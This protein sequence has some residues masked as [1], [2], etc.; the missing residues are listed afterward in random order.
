MLMHSSTFLLLAAASSAVIVRVRR[1]VMSP[2]RIVLATTFDAAGTAVDDAVVLLAVVDAVVALAI[3]SV[4]QHSDCTQYS[5][6][7]Q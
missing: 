4:V 2:I 5:S 6:S 1:N 3:S 7:D